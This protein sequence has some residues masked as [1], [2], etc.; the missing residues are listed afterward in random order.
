MILNCKICRS[1]DQ[2]LALM[3]DIKNM[4]TRQSLVDHI[5]HKHDFIIKKFISQ[6]GL[7]EHEFLVSTMLLK[8]NKIEL[9]KFFFRNFAKVHH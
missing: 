7:M 4:N 2:G 8:L 3:A 1:S 6:V 5:S 9:Q